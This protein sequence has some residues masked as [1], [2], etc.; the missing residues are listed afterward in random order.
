MFLDSISKGDI[1]WQVG[2]RLDVRSRCHKS[3]IGRRLSV[4][5]THRTCPVRSHDEHNKT[6]GQSLTT[7]K[8]VGDG[9]GRD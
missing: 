3:M 9:K 5:F 2:E 4:P 1:G 8:K 7:S 6:R